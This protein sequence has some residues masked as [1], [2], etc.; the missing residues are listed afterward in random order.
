MKRRQKEFLV[1][2]PIHTISFFR[3]GRTD[4]AQPD[5][6]RRLTDE[7]KA[8]AARH[9]LKLGDPSFRVGY[10]SPLQRTHETLEILS[11]GSCVRVETVNELVHD[12]ST[13]SGKLIEAAFEKLGYASIADYLNKSDDATKAALVEYGERAWNALKTKMGSSRENTIVVGHAVLLGLLIMAAYP[14]APIEEIYALNF[15]ECEGAKL[16]FDETGACI[17]MKKLCD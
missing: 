14:N 16:S 10:V 2:K 6:A 7:G 8:Q 11:G 3:H 17:D 12:T 5:S 13:D 4:K 15:G 9:R 1:S